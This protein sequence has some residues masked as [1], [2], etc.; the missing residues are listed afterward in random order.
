MMKIG[1]NIVQLTN[2]SIGI[3]ITNILRRG[4]AYFMIPFFNN[5]T[6]ELAVE[7]ENSL[8][9]T[10]DRAC[11][12]N[13][14]VQNADASREAQVKIGRWAMH[15][16]WLSLYRRKPLIR[17]ADANFFAALSDDIREQEKETFASLTNVNN[18]N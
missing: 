10:S 3:E 14:N 8:I 15:V 4:Q 9:A 1:N 13:K 5:I 12:A 16:F 2:V 6:N 11:I 7:I 17:T 18:Q